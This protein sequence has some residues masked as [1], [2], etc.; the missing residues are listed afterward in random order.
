MNHQTELEQVAI[1]ISKKVLN[2]ELGVI[3]GSMKLSEMRM[4]LN[5]ENDPTY[6]IFALV[7]SETDHLPT[8]SSRKYW[9]SEALRIKD[10]E[11]KQIEDLRRSDVLEACKTICLSEPQGAIQSEVS[12]PLARSSLTP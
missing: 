12:T 10:A 5:K 8:G 9:N 7:S 4:D 3:A 6:D 2:G 1:S 11:I